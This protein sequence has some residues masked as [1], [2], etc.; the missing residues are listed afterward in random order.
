MIG[1]PQDWTLLNFL[2]DSRTGLGRFRSFRISNYQLMMLLIDE[3]L[4]GEDS[5]AQILSGPDVQERVALYREQTE[6]FIEL[7]LVTAAAGCVD[8]DA[9]EP[10]FRIARFQF[11]E[12]H[13]L[14]PVA[15]KPSGS[16]YQN[17]S[18]TQAAPAAIQT[19]AGEP[20]RSRIPAT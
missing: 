9:D 3:V 12:F 4:K 19:T 6:L 1:S 10:R 14:L 20:G 15:R 16:P 2:M 7:V 18:S 8:D 17:P 11:H 5:I 13:R